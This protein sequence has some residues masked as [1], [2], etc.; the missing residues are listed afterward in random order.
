MVKPILKRNLNLFTC[1]EHKLESEPSSSRA[2]YTGE[3]VFFARTAA[4]VGIGS[5]SVRAVISRRCTCRSLCVT[6]YYQQ[7]LSAFDCIRTPLDFCIFSCIQ[8]QPALQAPNCV[9]GYFVGHRSNRYSSLWK[10]FPSQTM[11]HALW[12]VL[13]LHF[14][15]A[16]KAVNVE[17][18]LLIKVANVTFS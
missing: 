1:R 10:S 6:I 16:A 7:W 15:C 5:A 9:R 4:V 13:R 18:T 2:I 14:V 3:L 12:R 17:S 8:L 11:C